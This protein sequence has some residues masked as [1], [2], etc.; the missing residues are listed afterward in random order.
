MSIT[1]SRKGWGR[2]PSCCQMCANLEAGRGETQQSSGIKLVLPRL[3]E[4][5]SRPLDRGVAIPGI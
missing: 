3:I 1:T 2:M 5:S 4:V